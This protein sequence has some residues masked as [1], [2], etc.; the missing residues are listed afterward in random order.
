MNMRISRQEQGQLES[1]IDNVDKLKTSVKLQ[2][3]S[4]KIVDLRAKQEMI[5]K[6]K[7]EG[8]GAS[9]SAWDRQQ[10]LQKVG[11]R[12][13]ADNAAAIEKS[14]SVRTNMNINYMIM[15]ARDQVNQAIKTLSANDKGMNELRIEK[16]ANSTPYSQE[17][18]TDE[19]SDHQEQVKKSRYLSIGSIT[20]ESNGSAQA[21]KDG[22]QG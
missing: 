21:K 3:A 8:T 20:L 1:A 6:A 16:L 15:Q 19:D 12:E 2:M 10:N 11:M 9:M 17:T 4:M 22:E 7:K 18:S 5:E 13:I 14:D